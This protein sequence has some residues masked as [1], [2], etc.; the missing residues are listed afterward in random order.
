MAIPITPR[1]QASRHSAGLGRALARLI[2]PLALTLS[3]MLGGAAVGGSAA[4]AAMCGDREEILARLQQRHDESPTAL[5]LSSDGGVLEVLV[6]PEGGWTILITYPKRPTCV[7]AV[8]EA[9]QTL[10]LAGQPA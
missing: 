5:G 3:V 8:G 9:W 1:D 4:A 10:Q 2:G 7:V 6:S